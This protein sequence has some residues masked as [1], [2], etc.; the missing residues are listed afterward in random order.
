MGKERWLESLPS[1]VPGPDEL[2]DEPNE[3]R[4]CAKQAD[5]GHGSENLEGDFG[6]CLRQR[7]QPTA[8]SQR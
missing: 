3:H 4:C 1:A 5:C 7:L 6:V 2:T 8:Q